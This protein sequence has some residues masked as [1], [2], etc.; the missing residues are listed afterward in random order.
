[1]ENNFQNQDVNDINPV[2]SVEQE[3]HLSKK[4]TPVLKIFLYVFLTIVLLGSAFYAVMYFS[5]NFDEEEMVEPSSQEV[6]ETD[7]IA[8]K[9]DISES[10]LE[11]EEFL[12]KE[13]EK[14][15]IEKYEVNRKT[16][17]EEK[18]EFGGMQWFLE[19]EKVGLIKKYEHVHFDA[20][21]PLLEEDYEER[22]ALANHARESLSIVFT[23]LKD[24][25]WEKGFEEKDLE[26]N[27]Y[28]FFEKDSVL[29]EFTRNGASPS[30]SVKCGSVE[31]LVISETY[32]EI[33]Q[34]YDKD[35][36]T[37]EVHNVFEGFVVFSKSSR[38]PMVTGSWVIAQK[39]DGV[40]EEKVS[41]QE[42]WDCKQLF[43][44]G[45]KPELFLGVVAY[46]ECYDS[47]I[48]WPDDNT[49]EYEKYYEERI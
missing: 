13:F 48:E 10:M 21:S 38:P 42:P 27:F 45:V 30:M 43:E 47:E 20:Y 4:K 31:D 17:D 5:G 34:L 8:E 18:T 19:D 1:M 23:K 3:P 39:I 36:T 32:T 7:V 41:V 9:L 11:I 16:E 37:V 6:R 2:D 14:N 24:F 29:C 12:L 40:W 35:Y 44:W 49:L 26:E 33:Y 28:V 25:F 46:S 22:R 15:G